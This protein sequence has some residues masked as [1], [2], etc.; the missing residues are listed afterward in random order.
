MNL[1]EVPTDL[2]KQLPDKW[3]STVIAAA[4]AIASFSG[5]T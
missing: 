5:S 4:V 1:S 2:E 3:T